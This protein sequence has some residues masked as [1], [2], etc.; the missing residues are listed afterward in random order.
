VFG[1]AYR[2]EVRLHANV[3]LL[4]IVL[5]PF[6]QTSSL[7]K[8]V[9]WG[10]CCGIIM[11]KTNSVEQFN[12]VSFSVV[13]TRKCFWLDESVEFFVRA[14]LVEPDEY[15]VCG[16]LELVGGCVGV[17]V[18]VGVGYVTAGQVQGAKAYDF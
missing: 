13:G 17:G 5:C 9:L 7:Y 16:L 18:G 2:F 3:F 15:V 14:E 11:K 8:G 10:K 6:W 1:F 12:R 4:I